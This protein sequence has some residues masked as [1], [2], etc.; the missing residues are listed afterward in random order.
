[1]KDRIITKKDL[2]ENNEIAEKIYNE[3]VIILKKSRKYMQKYEKDK[4]Y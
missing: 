2:D 3:L 4:C 1:M